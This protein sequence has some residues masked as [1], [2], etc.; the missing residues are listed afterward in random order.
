MKARLL[1]EYGSKDTD[2][3]IWKTM[4]KRTQR[5]GEHFMTFYRDIDDLHARLCTRKSDREMIDLI[6]CNVRD[7]LALALA[8]FKTTS[9][10]EFKNLCR[11]VDDVI[12]K[13]SLTSSSRGSVF[14]KNISEIEPINQDDEC[15]VDAINVER[16]YSRKKDPSQYVCFNCSEKGHGFRDCPSEQRLLFCYRCGEKNVTSPNCPACLENRRRSDLKG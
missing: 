4:M 6:K 16:S 2:I 5:P 3:D 10:S 15:E 13:R 11:D 1:E 8:P 7:E 12:F 14:K 9:L